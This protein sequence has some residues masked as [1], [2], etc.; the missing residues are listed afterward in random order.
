MDS[1][2]QEPWA[3]SWR[4]VRGAP[5]ELEEGAESGSSR[6]SVEGVIP[7]LGALAGSSQNKA[8]QDENPLSLQVMWI[9]CSSTSWPLSSSCSFT[10]LHDSQIVCR[11]GALG[12][13]GRCPEATHG[14]LM[15]PGALPFR[16]T[17]HSV[18]CVHM[19]GLAQSWGPCRF[20]QE[21]TSGH[22]RMRRISWLDQ[23][24]G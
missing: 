15:W 8:R 12:A 21:V 6:K 14:T 2:P 20:L 13:G 24:Q 16:D 5:W 22:G 4:L 3:A 1:C 7:M 17:G 11:T 9:K 18:P 23:H 10:S 19:E